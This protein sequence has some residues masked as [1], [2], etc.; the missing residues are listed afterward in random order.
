MFAERQIL[1]IFAKK[2]V[3]MEKV[4]VSKNEYAEI[5]YMPELKLAQITWEGTVPS[6]EYR[7]TFSAAIEYTETHDFVNFVS[8]AREQGVV[9]TDDR[10]WFQKVIVPKAVKQGLKYGAV[11]IKKEP[12]KKYYMNAILRILNRKSNIS[13]RIFY[14]YDEAIVWLKKNF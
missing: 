9:S 2:T 12:F 11:V 3:I 13:M 14:D 1:S 5:V 6:E 7:K 4:I 8:D 10:K